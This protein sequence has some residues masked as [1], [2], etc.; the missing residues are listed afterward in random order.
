MCVPQQIWHGQV[1]EDGEHR[2][3]ASVKSV[4]MTKSWVRALIP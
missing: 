3:K 2:L 4:H 1:A